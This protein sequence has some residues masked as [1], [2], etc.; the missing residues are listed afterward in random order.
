MCLGSGTITIP[1]VFY[2]N[3]IVFGTIL[4]C[5][6]AL[7]SLYTGWL[8]VICCSKVNGSSYEEVALATYGPTMKKITSGCML[9][10]L[11]GFVV[12]YI[13]LVQLFN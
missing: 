8:V 11:I 9:A 10:C 3:G 12:S 4:I 13:V 7:I 5:F 6:G 2:A 1:Y